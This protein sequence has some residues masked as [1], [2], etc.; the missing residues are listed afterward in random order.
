MAA[1]QLTTCSVS[2]AMAARRMASGVIAGVSAMSEGDG[3][4]IGPSFPV[5]FAPAQ[6][7][8][9]ND[10][11]DQVPPGHVIVIDAGGRTDLSAW[12]GLIALE[13][14]RLGVRATVIHGA[15][16]DVGDFAECGFPVFARG[17]SPRS[18]RGWLASTDPGLP[19]TIDDVTVS[20]GDFVVADRDGV[21][22]VPG[23]S[24]DT[25]LDLAR[26]IE[27]RDRLIAADVRN[28]HSLEQSRR[29]HQ[30]PLT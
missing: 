10:Y 19:I 28:G 12:G 2:D 22:I 6:G 18:G 24:A 9:F 1:E 11:L 27:S 26:S 5:R 4:I 30:P 21:V 23:E 7:G 3:V 16:R 15:C 20:M 17:T 13:A 25:V 29:R 8:G 14:K